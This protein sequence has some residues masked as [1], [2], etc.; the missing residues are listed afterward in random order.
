MR[1]ISVDLF[2]SFFDK[3]S[4]VWMPK[5]LAAFNSLLSVPWVPELLIGLGVSAL[6]LSV[7]IR[8]KRL[9]GAIIATIMVMVPVVLV[10][11]FVMYFSGG[12]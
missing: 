11:S 9:D 5:I 10:F 4:T 1:L 8:D 7:I 3:F 2:S 6:I 12:V